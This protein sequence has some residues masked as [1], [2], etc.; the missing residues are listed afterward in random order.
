MDW[1]S[2]RQRFFDSALQTAFRAFWVA[3]GGAALTGGAIAYGL[4]RGLP[5]YWLTAFGGACVAFV[6]VVITTATLVLF[7]R[8]RHNVTARAGRKG[9]MDYKIQSTRALNR[10]TDELVGIMSQMTRMGNQVKSDTRR[11]YKAQQGWLGSDERAYKAGLQAASRIDKRAMIMRIHA[12]KFATD[13]ALFTEGSEKWFDW[14]IT[15]VETDA[16]RQEAKQV[17]DLL[18]GLHRTVCGTLT[19][20]GIFAK[21]VEE[22]RNMSEQMDIACGALLEAVNIFIDSTNSIKMFC[23][24]QAPRLRAIG[25]GTNPTNILALETR[26]QP[27]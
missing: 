6:M 8:R 7:H 3:V 4:I 27:G 2:I 12:D 17:A 19:S 5:L 22:S 10:L 25:G 1:Q 18:D 21:S 24:K 9:F 14:F 23:E 26:G 20:M 15:A 13:A 16:H 11:L